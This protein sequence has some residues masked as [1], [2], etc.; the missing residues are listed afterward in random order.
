MTVISGQS[1]SKCGFSSSAFVSPE[2][3]KPLH[4]LL[5][6]LAWRCIITVHQPCDVWLICHGPPG[7]YLPGS[8]VMAHP[9]YTYL[10]HP[11][12]S[13]EENTWSHLHTFTC[14]LPAV[15]NTALWWCSHTCL[16][17]LTCIHTHMHQHTH[18]C[19]THTYTH[20]ATHTQTD[21]ISLFGW[22]EL[23]SLN[24]S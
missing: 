13:P 2:S 1:R 6:N 18:S 24:I 8:S 14:T 4:F 19:H 5:P 22:Q 15:S 7:I 17:A 23:R 3:S 11:S 16:L 20:A 9:E 21:Q 12:W 10:D